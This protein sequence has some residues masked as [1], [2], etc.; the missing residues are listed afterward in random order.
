MTLQWWWIAWPWAVGL[1]SRGRT[2]ATAHGGEVAVAKGKAQIQVKFRPASKN[3]LARGFLARVAYLCTDIADDG[4]RGSYNGYT[5]CTMECGQQNFT[6]SAQRLLQL[7]SSQLLQDF[8]ETMT[9]TF[10]KD[11]LRREQKVLSWTNVVDAEEWMGV[12]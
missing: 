8:S 4:E 2:A 10:T 7:E 12:L 6:F 9:D 11:A 1:T 5:S 3:D